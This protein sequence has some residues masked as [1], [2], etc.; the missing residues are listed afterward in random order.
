MS[1]DNFMKP[2]LRTLPLALIAAQIC[3][4]ASAATPTPSAL[5]DE[6]IQRPGDFSQ[7]C[8]APEPVP[9]KAPPLPLYG[10]G[11]PQPFQ[12]SDAMRAELKNNRDAVVK[13][14]GARLDKL[15]WLN[16]PP[17]PKVPKKALFPTKKEEQGDMDP[18]TPSAQN[19][20]TL[21]PVMLSIIVELNAKELLPQ[22]LKLE[23]Q[24]NT[25]NEAGLKNPA[26]APLAKVDA[27]GFAMWQGADEDYK[28][29]EDWDKA[30]PKLKRKRQLFE[31]LVFDRELLGVMLD[32]VNQSHFAP[33]KSTQL[34]EL[35]AKEI[36]SKAQ[37][38][39]ML[40]AV[41]TPEDL[42]KPDLK[43]VGIDF[44]AELGVPY[45]R[46]Q[47]VLVPYTEERRAEARKVI[48]DFVA[49]NK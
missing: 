8:D 24:L 13:E 12:L 33:L 4:A 26:K 14:I 36:K 47:H 32:L 3:S 34:A 49:A 29:V 48:E 11:V 9:Y 18:N 28:D 30:P 5:L 42:K 16:P 17:A 1:D 10:L 44:D 31:A 43:D 22:L 41:K 46:W 7:T 23:E 27:G 40:R 20:R 25:L 35:R 21:S 45:W 6:A 39:E 19:P 37:T 38:D 2:L 15:D